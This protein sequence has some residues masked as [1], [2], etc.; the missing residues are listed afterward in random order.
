MASA[1]RLADYVDPVS[2]DLRIHEAHGEPLK[3]DEA[4]GMFVSDMWGHPFN[5]LDAMIGMPVEPIEPAIWNHRDKYRE[6]LPPAVR[7][8]L[9][10]RPLLEAVLSVADNL[11]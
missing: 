3:P 6:S 4:V 10:L 11:L 1:R 7:D 5:N 2:S 9:S 8:S